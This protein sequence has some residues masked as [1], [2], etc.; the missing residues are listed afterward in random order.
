[1]TKALAGGFARFPRE[2]GATKLS[3]PKTCRSAEA[4]LST[5][6][7]AVVAMLTPS[8]SGHEGVELSIGG[9]E[10]GPQP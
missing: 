10:P 2:P 9:R 3:T 8:V 6:G 4:G 7:A 1:M 5:R